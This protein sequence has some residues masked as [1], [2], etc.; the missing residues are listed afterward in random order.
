VIAALTVFLA[1]AALAPKASAWLR[2]WIGSLGMN[3]WWS[4][5]EDLSLAWLLGTAA[6]MTLPLVAVGLWL[7]LAPVLVFLALDDP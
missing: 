6:Y 3:D 7:V 5:P 1:S 4:L 2:S